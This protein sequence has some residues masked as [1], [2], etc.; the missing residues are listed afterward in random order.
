MGKTRFCCFAIC[1]VMGCLHEVKSL[2][3]LK[4][5]YTLQLRNWYFQKQMHVLS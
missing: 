3:K 4:I 1:A 2:Q 5:S